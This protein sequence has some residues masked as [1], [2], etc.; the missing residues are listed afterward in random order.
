MIANSTHINCTNL[1]QKAL[2]CIG[3]PMNPRSSIITLRPPKTY[4]LE[5]LKKHPQFKVSYSDFAKYTSNIQENGQSHLGSLEK[6]NADI[7]KGLYLETKRVDL[8]YQR[9]YNI[10]T[11]LES[12]I[13]QSE[14]IQI[15]RKDLNGRLEQ[16]QKFKNMETN[17]EQE[18]E[19][20]KHH[21][22]ETRAKLQEKI[23]LLR[24]KKIET[25]SLT[26]KVDTLKQKL[27]LKKAGQTVRSSMNM[28]KTLTRF[29]VIPSSRGSRSSSTISRSLSTTRYPQSSRPESRSLMRT[30]RLPSDFTWRGG[31][32]GDIRIH[33]H[34]V[35]FAADTG[36]SSRKNSRTPLRS[37]AN[38]P[39]EEE[40]NRSPR[41]RRVPTNS[42]ENSPKNSQLQTNTVNLE[43]MNNFKNHYANENIEQRNL[44]V[45][46]CS[47]YFEV[48]KLFEEGWRLWE[49]TLQQKNSTSNK[50]AGLK[51][52]M[53]F[54]VAETKNKL[55]NAPVAMWSY[56]TSERFFK[57]YRSKSTTIQYGQE[58]DAKNVMRM[59]FDRMKQERI[60]HTKDQKVTNLLSDITKEDIRSYNA[61]QIITLFSIRPDILAL[62]Q[63][64][65]VTKKQQICEC[66]AQV[67][68]IHLKN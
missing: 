40:H 62:L 30:S 37:G 49:K 33:D 48:F 21:I 55:D 15:Q 5:N 27:A 68:V 4:R 11:N 16:L 2:S 6:R 14:P 67:N 18:I 9:Q 23:E 35:S 3:N 58:G 25:V 10:M 53:L 59:T 54:L 50:A 45:S 66:S 42:L 36:K 61:L 38:T 31:S 64:P 20:L 39:F 1:F 29:K 65:F 24:A 63:R 12:I 41:S 8:T 28:S 7:M 57:K 47:T 13:E 43:M 56:Q 44:I 46:V 19:R 22:T 60:F 52:S 34:R 17:V 32:E 26:E 51:G